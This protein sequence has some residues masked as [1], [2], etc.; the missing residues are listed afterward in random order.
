M[1]EALEIDEL[2][3]LGVHQDQ[4]WLLPDLV[5]HPGRLSRERLSEKQF[6]VIQ[7]ASP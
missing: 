2:R 6:E 5:Q 4:A 1:I 3:A 7:H